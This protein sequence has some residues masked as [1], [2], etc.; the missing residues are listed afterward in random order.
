MAGLIGGHPMSP[1]FHDRLDNIGL[2]LLATI[3]L[4]LLLA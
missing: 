1:A 4:L 3:G 2:A